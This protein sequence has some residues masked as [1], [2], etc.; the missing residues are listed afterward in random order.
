MSEESRRLAEEGRID[1]AL[2]VL[3][4]HADAGDGPL[5]TELADLLARHDR[6]DELRQRAMAGN[7]DAGMALVRALVRRHGDPEAAAV[8]QRMVDAGHWP[9]V[10]MMVDSLR[11]AGRPDDAVALLRRFAEA[12]ETYASVRL[13]RW[14][15][16]EGRR[17]EALDV[18]RPAAATGNRDALAD[19]ASSLQSHGGPDEAIAALR[20]YVDRGVVPAAIQLAELLLRLDRIDEG[21]ELMRSVAQE[22]EVAAWRSG[23][24]L[25]ER[26]RFEEAAAAIRSSPKPLSTLDVVYWTLNNDGHVFAAEAIRLAIGPD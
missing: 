8:L 17:D 3:R 6:L 2:A 12:G 26:G 11:A 14:L 9:A 15:R 16:D 19:L 10:S 5:A 24:L 1:E 13:A 23:A 18:L 25:G 7:H 4:P 21:I 22:D 20:E